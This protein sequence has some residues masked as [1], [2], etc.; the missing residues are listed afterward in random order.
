MNWHDIVA[1]PLFWILSGT[2]S[3]VLS[4]VANLLTPRIRALFTRRLQSRK[5]GLREKQIRRRDTILT[6]QANVQRR[7]GAKLDAIFKL[8]AAMTLLVLSLLLFQ[9]GFGGFPMSATGA[10]LHELPVPLLLFVLLTLLV[11]TVLVRLGLDDMSLA[12][13]ADK[14]EQAGDEFLKQHRP[15][16]SEEKLQ[17]EDGWDKNEFGVNSR[18]IALLTND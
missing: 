1:T 17:F 7:T 12:L 2:G 5:S 8:L 16:S 11:A 18:D 15:A 9:L 3:V 13:T 10:P 6:L 14:R 4:V